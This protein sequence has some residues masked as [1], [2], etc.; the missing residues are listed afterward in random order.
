M[1]F[2][3]KNVDDSP[4][5]LCSLPDCVLLWGHI[6]LLFVL[7]TLESNTSLA[8]SK[9]AVCVHWKKMGKME[10]TSWLQ[11]NDLLKRLKEEKQQMLLSL[12]FYTRGQ[13]T[14]SV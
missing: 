3:I 6:Q 14:C 5:H 9:H 4:V 7:L 8:Q 1:L 12:I 11:E 10:A 13:Q 2:Y